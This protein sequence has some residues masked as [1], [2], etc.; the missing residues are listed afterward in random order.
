MDDLIIIFI[1]IS[2]IITIFSYDINRKLFYLFKPL[3]TLLI[4]AL[5][6]SERFEIITPY[7]TY[8]AWGLILSLAGDILLMMPERYFIHGIGAFFAT[9]LLYLIAIVGINGWQLYLYPLIPILIFVA[10]LLWLLLPR[11]GRLFYPVLAYVSIVF[12]LLWQASGR[13]I[14]DESASAVIALAGIIL[15]ALS[16]SILAIDKF[17][18]RLPMAQAMI[19]STY[20]FGQTLIALSI[21]AIRLH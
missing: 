15:F 7:Q 10:L 5:C 1:I 6:F 13:F 14:A 21:P 8:I 16:D 3:T 2:A 11:T 17:V 19:L 12:L 9:H 4:I 20:Y 18:R